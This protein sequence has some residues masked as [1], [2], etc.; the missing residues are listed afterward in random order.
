MENLLY[1][2]NTG[3]HTRTRTH[4]IIRFQ[5]TYARQLSLA[6]L[7]ILFLMFRTVCVFIYVFFH[8]ELKNK[9]GISFVDAEVFASHENNY[10]ANITKTKRKTIQHQQTNSSNPIRFLRSTHKSKQNHENILLSYWR[11]W[12]INVRWSIISFDSIEF[13][14]NII[15]PLHTTSFLFMSCCF[16]L[17]AAELLTCKKSSNSI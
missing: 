13:Y 8:W 10:F 3:A 14:I 6:M 12:L 4:T 7:N 16:S 11:T 5:V 2:P 15:F 9:I 17:R 1:T